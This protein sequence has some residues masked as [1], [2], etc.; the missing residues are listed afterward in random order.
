MPLGNT[1]QLLGVDKIDG[2]KTGNTPAS[3]GCVVITAEKPA[4]VLKQA[5]GSSVVFRHRMV[6]VVLGSADPFGEARS[7]LY[8]GWS[9]YERWLAAGRPV[10]DPRQTLTGYTG[11]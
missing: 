7:L 6:V 9:G 4:T 1:N 2:M 10:T 5:D 3:G 8:Q 11:R